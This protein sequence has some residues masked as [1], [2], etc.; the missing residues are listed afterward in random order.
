MNVP[1]H[2]SKKLLLGNN[3]TREA[4]TWDIAHRIELASNDTKNQTKWLEEFDTSLQSIMKKFSLGKHHTQLRNT[5]IKMETSFLEFCLFSETRFIEYAHR[6]YDHF[7]KMYPVLITKIRSDVLSGDITDQLTSDREFTENILAQASFVFHLIFIREI[8]HLLTRFSKSSQKFDVLPFYGMTSYEKTIRLL[9]CARD[10]FKNNNAP[11]PEP[12]E[13]ETKLSKFYLWEDFNNC[14]NTIIQ[15][16][17]FHKF[18]LLLPSERGRVTRSGSR[19]GC[20]DQTS[21][22]DIKTHCFSKFSTYIDV[23]LFNLAC[24]FI[25][26]PQWAVLSNDCFNFL[27]P[28]TDEKRIESLTL[29]MNEESGTMPLKTDEKMRLKAEYIKL[30][31]N[32]KELSVKTEYN[33]SEKNWY[34]LLTNKELYEHC[35]NI[36]EFSLRFLTRTF[37][38]CSVESQ[39][40][41]INSIDTSSRRLKHE[42]SQKLTFISSNGPSPLVAQMVVEDGLND[43]FKGNDWHFVM[44][45]TNYYTSKVVDRHIKDA[46]A[47]PNDLV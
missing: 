28:K 10:S 6:T 40:S 43:Y 3:F 22:I 11:K 1:D 27:D 5:A 24:R 37:N 7:Y 20:G 4:V 2:L 21:Y 26:W 38:E 46:K 17:T 39:V 18:Q 14:T 23:L 13:I 32:G 30:L 41:A 25:P 16:Q 12:I 8:S 34:E 47:G 45:N 15:D 42:T 44:S 9:T 29:L 35:Y 33:T 19:F 31:I 36:N